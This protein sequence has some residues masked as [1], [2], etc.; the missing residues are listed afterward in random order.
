MAMNGVLRRVAGAVA[1][2]AV[3]A[4]A[5]PLAGIAQTNGRAAPRTVSEWA[6]VQTNVSAYGAILA[7]LE[8]LASSLRSASLPDSLLVARLDEGLKKRIPSAALL[9]ALRNDTSRFLSIA[10]TMRERGLLPKKPEDSAS[11]VEQTDILVRAG[12]GMTE[13]ERTLDAAIGKQGKTQASLARSIAALAVAAKATATFHLDEKGRIRLA[14]DLVVCDLAE[15]DFDS[16]LEAMARYMDTGL[17]TLESLESAL[18]TMS[19]KGKGKGSGDTEAGGASRNGKLGNE[20]SDSRGQG[21]Q[22]GK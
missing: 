12:M 11:I 15:K 7:E 4:F 17:S 19:G 5:I 18:G 13:L 10:S 2:F 20:N 3:M 1:I 9:R 6:L 14:T 8:S 21:S 22:K 16:V